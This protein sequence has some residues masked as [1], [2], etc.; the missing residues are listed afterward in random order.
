L[1]RRPWTTVRRL[2]QDAR[3]RE[4]HISAL[5]KKIEYSHLL[6]QLLSSEAIL[7]FK[8]LG[9]FLLINMTNPIYDTY[10]PP[11]FHTMNAYMTAKDPKP[12][13]EFLKK[14]FHAVE[15]HRTESDGI[16]RNVGL[17]IGDSCFMLGTHPNPMPSQFYLFVDDPDAMQA[18]AIEL[19]AVEIM[20]VK[21]QAYHDRQGGVE[22]V[23]G[24]KWWISKRLKE[25]P[26]S[27][28]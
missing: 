11:G 26:Y 12:L 18:R 25:E 3:K 22:D 24:N 17:R 20:K 28:H 15:D 8:F 19:G 27:A 2:Q 6:S 7:L 13:T 4:V 1:S 16:I 5:F 10:K 21:D 9:S 14:A 23:A